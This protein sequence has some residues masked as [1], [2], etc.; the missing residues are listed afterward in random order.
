MSPARAQRG[1]NAE[2][3]LSK[4]EQ[5][6]GQALP[7]PVSSKPQLV[8]SLPGVQSVKNRKQLIVS[9]ERPPIEDVIEEA[10][11]PRVGNASDADD[12]L[13]EMDEDLH[14]APL[15]LEGDELE[16][17]RSHLNDVPLHIKRIRKGLLSE[18]RDQTVEA[19]RLPYLAD[20]ADDT[21]RRKIFLGIIADSHM[22]ATS[23][24]TPGIRVD[25]TW[26]RTT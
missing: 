25:D 10:E 21:Q 4:Y 14:P 26:W 11:I 24:G 3:C 19:E 2:L 17:Q 22:C 16:R 18:I 23:V 20:G 12:T 8:K 9:P 13:V 1:E 5:E 15:R 7:R 6:R